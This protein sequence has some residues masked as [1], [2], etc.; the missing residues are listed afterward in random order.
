MSNFAGSGQLMPEDLFRSFTAQRTWRA[1]T[2]LLD[3]LEHAALD[4]QLH[5]NRIPKP[6]HVERGPDGL[7]ITAD[8]AAVTHVI[9]SI[10]AEVASR[11]SVTPFNSAVRP[12]HADQHV[13]SDGYDARVYA[14]PWA[15]VIAADLFEPFAEARR[16]G[17]SAAEVEQAWRQMGLRF[18][19]TFL[20]LGGSVD[21]AEVFRMCRGRDPSLKPILEQCGFDASA[22]INRGLDLNLYANLATAAEPQIMQQLR[23]GFSAIMLA[24]AK[25]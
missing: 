1:A 3:Q 22:A 19:D 14:Y 7:V 21:P 17:N 20:A 25:R 4:Q 9:R 13:F 10:E 8:H 23:K 18:R 24:V 2:R 15:Q 11:W 6:T 5:A 16:N 12:L